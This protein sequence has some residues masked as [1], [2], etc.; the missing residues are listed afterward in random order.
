MMDLGLLDQAQNDAGRAAHD[1]Q[2]FVTLCDERDKLAFALDLM[3]QIKRTIGDIERDCENQIAQ[4]SDDNQFDVEQLGHVQIRRSKR[5]TKWD[6]EGLYKAVAKSY[7]Y[8][9]E[10]EMSPTEAVELLETYR[11]CV[12]TGA[13]KNAFADYTGHDLDEYCKEEPGSISVQITTP[14]SAPRIEGF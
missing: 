11:E 7:I 12:S 13:G 8:K 2:E 6:H 14:E 1:L 5:R 9:S 3:R 10:R 4:C